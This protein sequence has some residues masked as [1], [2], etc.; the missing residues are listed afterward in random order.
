M[1]GSS[2]A[3]PLSGS[4]RIADRPCEEPKGQQI[5]TEESMETKERLDTALLVV[6]A[7]T[8]GIAMAADAGA[9]P[10]SDGLRVWASVLFVVIA[11]RWAAKQRDRG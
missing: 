6:A 1:P 4:D 5:R 7:A 2:G 10:L 8:A 11:V 9:V 3:L